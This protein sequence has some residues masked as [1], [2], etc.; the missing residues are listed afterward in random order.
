VL[1]EDDKSPPFQLQSDGVEVAYFEKGAQV[2][3]LDHGVVKSLITS[4]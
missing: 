1:D 4:D 2:F 3:F